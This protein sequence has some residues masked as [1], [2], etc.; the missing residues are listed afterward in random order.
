MFDNKDVAAYKNI[1]AP[2]NL[3]NKVLTSEKEYSNKVVFYKPAYLVAACMALVL[4][5]SSFG[6]WN[7]SSISVITPDT[8]VASAT[9]DSRTVTVSGIP[10]EVTTN[11]NRKVTVSQG[12]L[13]GLDEETG[14]IVKFGTEVLVKGFKE[15]SWEIDPQSETEYQMEITGW[16]KDKVYQLVYDQVTDTWNLEER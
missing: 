1:K 11:H 4:G 7:K 5:I 10:V 8:T 6:M 3:K 14:E 12:T 13:S 16:G 9:L 2:E 15:I